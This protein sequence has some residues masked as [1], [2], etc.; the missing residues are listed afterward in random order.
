MEH[1]T[2]MTA[3]KSPVETISREAEVVVPQ[4]PNGTHSKLSPE[5][6][7]NNLVESGN[8]S[9]N[10]GVAKESTAEPKILTQSASLLTSPTITVPL[11][12]DPIEAI[13]AL[14]DALEEVGKILPNVEPE[15]PKKPVKKSAPAKPNSVKRPPVSSTT[16]PGS[17]T[18][19][20]SATTSNKPSP[21]LTKSTQP[22]TLSRSTS[23]RVTPA[24]KAVTNPRTSTTANRQSMIAST[25]DSNFSATS[26]S[27]TTDYLAS[28]RRPISMQFPPPPTPAKSSKTPTRPT[29]TLPGDSILAKRRA[30][31]E[32]KLK[33]EQEELA[34][35]REFK[36]RPAP[37]SA[38]ARPTSMIVRQNASSMARASIMGAGDINNTLGTAKVNGSGSSTTLKRSGTVTGATSSTASKDKPATKRFSVSYTKSAAPAAANISQKRQSIV[39]PKTEATKRSSIIV[40]KRPAPTNTSQLSTTSRS[41]SGTRSM[42]SSTMSSVPGMT[43]TVI[44]DQITTL[45]QKGKQIY[46]RDRV[47]K[48]ERERERRDKEAAAKKA[49]AEASEKGRQASREWAEKQRKKLLEV[50]QQ[51]Q[52]IQDTTAS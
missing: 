42:A 27:T 7:Q 28:K 23:T 12:G 47:E 18:T 4:Q 13:D 50:K 25:K 15:S 10:N 35:K 38:K 9:W 34:K 1:T 16:K 31:M 22:S 46:N 32:D 30:L 45:K 51:R 5:D 26:S 20:S 41:A 52:Q 48:E 2:K 24:T 19:K 43:K 49:R 44:A 37:G 36:A 6:P 17:V 8:E 21:S 3:L 39:V 33:K 29:F 11:N 14:E 40:P